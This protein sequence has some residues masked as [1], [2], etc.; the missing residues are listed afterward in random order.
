M[1][2]RYFLFNFILTKINLML[3]IMFYKNKEKETIKSKGEKYDELKGRKEG[4]YK[5]LWKESLDFN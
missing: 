2:V 1:G 3:N 4:G 5:G